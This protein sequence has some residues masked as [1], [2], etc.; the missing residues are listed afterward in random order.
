MNFTSHRVKLFFILQNVV[1][2]KQ[3]KTPHLKIMQTEQKQTRKKQPNQNIPETKPSKPKTI[4]YLN[5]GMDP[6]HENHRNMSGSLC[7]S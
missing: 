3:N 5:S 2:E 4:F 6:L 7:Y 1:V